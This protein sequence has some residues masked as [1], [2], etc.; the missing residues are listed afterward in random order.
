MVPKTTFPVSPQL[1]HYLILYTREPTIVLVSDGEGEGGVVSPGRVGHCSH[2]QLPRR[3]SEP[4]SVVNL[5][6][7]LGQDLPETALNIATVCL[8]GVKGTRIES[9]GQT[10]TFPHVMWVPGVGQMAFQN[11][12]E[13]TEGCGLVYWAEQAESMNWRSLTDLSEILILIS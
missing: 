2:K 11:G 6:Q 5:I 8:D 7:P 12:H 3:S 13:T 9:Q 4:P 10:Q 1:S